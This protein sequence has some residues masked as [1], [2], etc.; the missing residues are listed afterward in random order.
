MSLQISDFVG[1]NTNRAVALHSAPTCTLWGT[2][3]ILSS[4]LVDADG[5][6]SSVLKLALVVDEKTLPVCGV[7]F[8]YPVFF[9]KEVE[10]KGGNLQAKQK[11]KELLRRLD[12]EGKESDNPM[13][14]A[15][16][17]TQTLAQ[18]LID[19]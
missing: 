19:P 16:T 1:T 6:A 2:T 10:L 7:R 8:L 15:L 13:R 9:V 12:I 17:L 5:H 4:H 11:A 14:C 3:A 18:S